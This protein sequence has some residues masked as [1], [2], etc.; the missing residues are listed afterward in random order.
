MYVNNNNLSAEVIS[1]TPGFTLR[2]GGTAG[3]AMEAQDF[4]GP[5]SCCS[6][7]HG[8]QSLKK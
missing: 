8:S 2:V 4:V 1:Q 5:Q 6:S 7:W 3:V